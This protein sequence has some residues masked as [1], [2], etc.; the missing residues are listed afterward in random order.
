MQDTKIAVDIHNIINQPFRI[1]VGDFD[2]S[3]ILL[4]A[5]TE[6]I[7]NNKLINPKNII[8]KVLNMIIYY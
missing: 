8:D 5:A 3:F 6:K 1:I 4:N 2:I 7:K